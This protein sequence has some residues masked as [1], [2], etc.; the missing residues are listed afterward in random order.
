[1]VAVLELWIGINN[2]IYYAIVNTSDLDE[3]GSY[4]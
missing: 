2:L 3:I 1:M 4:R